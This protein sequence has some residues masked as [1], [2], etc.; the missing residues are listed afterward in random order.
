MLL[1]R[2]TGLR[3]LQLVAASHW[4]AWRQRLPDQPIFYPVLTL[5]YAVQIA[6]DWNTID[7]FSGFVGFVTRF[8]LDDAFAARYP[9]QRAAGRAH[10]E[11]WVPAE[12]LDLF[13]CNLVGFIEVVAAF[14]G[15]RAAV[16]VDPLTHLPP[17]LSPPS[18]GLPD[19][20]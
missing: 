19:L 14:V 6:K 5:S 18:V 4:R 2:P 10:E 7:E 3:E 15:P 17:D 13:N 16:V 20:G 8:Q 11:L 9:V 1:Y 12:E